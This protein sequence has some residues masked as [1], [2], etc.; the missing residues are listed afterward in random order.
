MG[1]QDNIKRKPFDYLM[2]IPQMDEL[3]PCEQT[4]SDPQKLII[5]LGVRPGQVVD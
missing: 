3:E 4:P 1:I 5:M 2:S